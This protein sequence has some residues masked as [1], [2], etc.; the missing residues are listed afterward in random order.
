MAA[1]PE[2]LPGVPP[3]TAPHRGQQGHRTRVG[4]SQHKGFIAEQLGFD[5]LF[6]F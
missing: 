6:I 5:A 2:G 1:S 4:T 3:P